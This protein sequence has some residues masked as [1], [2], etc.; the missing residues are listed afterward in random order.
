[1]F[2]FA[3]PRA[4]A[5]MLCT[6][7]GLTAFP[8]SPTAGAELPVR[9]TRSVGSPVSF[10]NLT[11]IPVYDRGAK[12]TE[13][14]ITLDEAL[15]AKRVKVR[16]ASGGGEV[17][18]VL[19]SNLDSKPLYLMGGEVVL[20]GQQ[21]RCLGKDTIIPAGKRNASVTVFCVEHGRWNG[22]SDFMTSAPMVAA[23][24]VRA[25]VMAGAFAGEVAAAPAARAE[26]TR[27][28]RLPQ[29]VGSLGS[30]SVGGAQQKV[31]DT[32]AEKNRRFNTAP[33]SGTY[34]GVLN[35]E[36][37]DAQRRISPYLR[38]FTAGTEKT[39]HRVGVVAAINGK[40]IAADIFGD[41]TL[42]RRLWPKLLRS[43]AADA[44]EAVEG[45]GKARPVTSAQARDFLLTTA[46]GSSRMESRSD[47]STT[48]RLESK[49]ALLYRVT[50][51][52]APGAARGGGG[53]GGM[54]AGSGG[55]VHESFLRK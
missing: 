4:L 41:P 27:V 23:R 39:P 36:A 9:G 7:F 47:V 54:K 5:L 29:T 38:A 55:P 37:G 46:A 22:H 17:N 16:E 35:M 49:D 30:A 40:I 51:A 2:R 14:Y 15:K 34:R 50:P 25:S 52:G 6:G 24:E 33:A 26:A 18:S 1:M 3:V 45:S 8:L 32:V 20:G 13:K 19:I 48:L 42:F 21:D 12:P 31:W 53:S 44:A 11:L 28:S 10:R 43:Y